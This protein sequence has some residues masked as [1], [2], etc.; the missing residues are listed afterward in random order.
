MTRVIVLPA[1]SCMVYMLCRAWE[2]EISRSADLVA[3]TLTGYRVCMH[4]SAEQISSEHANSP[5]AYS[6]KN[7]AKNLDISE[8]QMW[9]LVR[10]EQIESIKIGRSRRISRSALLA[11]I[12]RHRAA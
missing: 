12:D 8:R 10:T 6:V 4:A 2:Q 9:E 1:L 11:F 3:S 7:A 5:L